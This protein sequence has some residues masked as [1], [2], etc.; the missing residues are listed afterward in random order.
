MLFAI[1]L[2]HKELQEDTA[3]FNLFLAWSTIELVRLATFI[4]NERCMVGQNQTNRS[5]N[6]LPNREA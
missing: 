2:P 4:P 3:V 5:V 6:R 1:L